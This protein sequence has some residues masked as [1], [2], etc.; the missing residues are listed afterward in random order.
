MKRWF[1]FVILSEQMI[2]SLVGV[3]VKDTSYY[4][5]I[6]SVIVHVFILAALYACTSRKKSRKLK[7]LYS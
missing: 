2:F 5:M 4:N 1:V 7:A 3:T 6:S